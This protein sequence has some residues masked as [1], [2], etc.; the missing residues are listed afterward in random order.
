M[1]STATGASEPKLSSKQ[2]GFSP[3]LQEDTSR[4][5][6][7]G[8]HHRGTGRAVSSRKSRGDPTSSSFS[9]PDGCR[10]PFSG[11]NLR[12]P[13]CRQGWVAGSTWA[14][15]GS[16]WVISTP[17]P[18]PFASYTTSQ[19]GGPGREYPGSHR[20]AHHS[21]QGRSQGLTEQRLRGEHGH[22][23]GART[24]ETGVTPD[25]EQ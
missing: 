6:S 21:D 12:L 8:R 20:P 14:I 10:V 1:F 9:A 4:P 2:Q 25:L 15:M 11:Q 7:L 24:E 13:P 5:V 17:Q 19:L 18:S 3:T 23:R 22:K 16:T